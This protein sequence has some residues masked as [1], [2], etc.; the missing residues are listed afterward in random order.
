MRLQSLFKRNAWLSM[1]FWAPLVPFISVTVFR[2]IFAPGLS[3]LLSL[4]FFK[5]SDLCLSLFVVGLFSKRSI[6]QADV[7][8][9][10]SEFLDQRNWAAQTAETLAFVFFFFFAIHEAL[11][12][13]VSY[14]SASFLDSGRHAL[15]IFVIVPSVGFYILLKRSQETFKLKAELQ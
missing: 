10:D 15:Q 13:F 11:D 2:I 3:G 7:G 9:N 4:Q 8:M 1:Y 5:A 14:L 6:L 12:Y